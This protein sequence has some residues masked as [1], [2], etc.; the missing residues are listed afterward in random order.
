[1]KVF[2]LHF[3]QKKRNDRIFKS[4]VIG[5]L[6]MA[7][8]LIGGLPQNSDFLNNL[9]DSIKNKFHD[10]ADFS[11]SLK[12]ANNFLDRETKL[13]NVNWLGNLN[14]AVLNIRDSFL[15]F[16]KVGDIK[17]LLL[18]DGEILDISQN[19]ELQD[20]EP[21]PLKIFSNIASGKLLAQ[22]KILILTDDIFLTISRNETIL[23]Q[24]SRVTKERELKNIFKLNKQI[25]SEISGA[26]LL[27][28]LNGTTSSLNIPVPRRIPKKL[29]L[30]AGLILIL[31]V[32]YSLFGNEKTEKTNQSQDSL[33][34][35]RSKIMMAENFI[36][37][38][39][40]EKAQA[41]YQEAWVILSS[42]K[43]EEAESLKE[44]IRKYIT[45]IPR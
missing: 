2:E 43:T 44:S 20:I 10:K 35:A 12:E 5:D 34:D 13:G 24:L 6:C 21:Y 38:R 9:S 23:D 8:E 4:F 33:E 19:L 32:S 42:V 16:T 29:I 11:E 40:E 37:M 26:C 36:I 18:R 25:V 7:G 28:V 41:L 3:N 30:V 1:M 17:I 15:H 31:L 22:D 14:F 39:K 45:S 27:I